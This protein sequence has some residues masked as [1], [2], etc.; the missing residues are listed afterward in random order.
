MAEDLLL[1]YF[2]G[3]G[4][5]DDR[6]EPYLA[7]RD[8][9]KRT[10]YGSAI[11]RRFLTGAMDRSRSRQ[12]I[13]ILDS[14]FAGDFTRAKGTNRAAT[15][16]KGN[17][18]GRVILAA[19]DEDAPLAFVD[20]PGQT[21]PCSVFTSYLVEGLGTGAADSNGRG[22]VTVNDLFQYTYQR[23]LSDKVP[24]TPS[25]FSDLQQGEIVIANAPNLR[26]RLPEAVRNALDVN[27][28]AGLI[29]AVDELDHLLQQANRNSLH[30]TALTV[31]RELS[32]HESRLVSKAASDCLRLHSPQA[33]QKDISVLD[34][35]KRVAPFIYAAATIFLGGCVFVLAMLYWNSDGL[36]VYQDVEKFAPL[37]GSNVFHRGEEVSIR[38]GAP[39]SVEGIRGFCAA[40]FLKSGTMLTEN[41]IC[42]CGELC[43]KGH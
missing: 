20:R 8:S 19:T 29:A 38:H 28:P 9:V 43:R 1:L 40:G 17:G 2:S 42:L 31:L 24:Q 26:A 30:P 33:R 11:E 25:F 41:N 22:Y 16:F 37:V 12:Q 14:C 5:L 4:I 32:H 7:V 27:Q 6:D 18:S 3:H 23:A 15:A 10:P 34:A 13:L 36:Y 39:G 21:G 35:K